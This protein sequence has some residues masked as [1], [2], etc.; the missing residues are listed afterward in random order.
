MES[1][2]LLDT[3]VISRL[4]PGVSFDSYEESANYGSQLLFEFEKSVMSDCRSQKIMM[5][6]TILREC[7]QKELDLTIKGQRN[8]LDLAFFLEKFDICV[9]GGNV[10]SNLKDLDKMAKL[11]VIRIDL[12]IKV[13]R[14]LMLKLATIDI[15]FDSR[16][17]SKTK[18]LSKYSKKDNEDGRMSVFEKIIKVFNS[19][20]EELNLTSFDRNL[21]YLVFYSIICI[22]LEIYGADAKKWSKSDGC[23]K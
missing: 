19:H 5:V 14:D 9:E 15:S 7:Y 17:E 23:Y 8:N 4:K 2:F 18:L 16:V 12:M 10:Y 22:I 3:N 6:P 11:Q 21:L 1:K 13:V 20:L